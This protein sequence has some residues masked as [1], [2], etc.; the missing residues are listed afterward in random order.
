ML[1]GRKLYERIFYLNADLQSPLMH[2]NV[3]TSIKTSEVA[4][5]V[6]SV[7]EIAFQVATSISL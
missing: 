6:K 1:P 5:K 3:K 4:K 7:R 2:V